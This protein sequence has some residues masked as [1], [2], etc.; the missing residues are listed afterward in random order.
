MTPISYT[1]LQFTSSI[2]FI[3]AIVHTFCAGFFKKLAHKYENNI[4]INHSNKYKYKLFHVLS[5]VELIFVLWAIV[6]ILFMLVNEGFKS[7]LSYIH[8]LRFIEPFFVLILMLVTGTKPIM[9]V[10]NIV[11][12]YVSNYLYKVIKLAKGISLYFICLALIPI[13]GSLISEPAAMTISALMLNQH[14]FSKNLSQSFKYT[15]LA[16]LFVNISI[17]GA[18][19]SFAAPPIL[20]VAHA[21]NWNTFYIFDTFGLKAILAV[22]I[23]TFIAIGLFYNNLAKQQLEHSSIKKEDK[24]HKNIILIHIIILS[25]VIIFAHNLIALALILLGFIAFINVYKDCPKPMMINQ[26][27][28]VFGFLASLVIIGGQQAWWLQPL[29][30]NMTSM[31]IFFGASV[32]TAVTDNAAITYLASLVSG[33]SED[34][35]YS[36][37]A[38]A[39]S[40]GG[41]TVIANAPNPIGASILQSNFKANIIKPSLLLLYALVPT[42]VCIFVFLPSN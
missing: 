38:G 4:N 5:E 11:S 18:L 26:S 24:I 32:L 41:L 27:I 30:L 33:L 19:T 25:C 6:L 10:T 21:W 7:T 42:L 16:V 35:K 1:L 37:V 3:I 29:L 22:L 23:N 12:A 28:M 39:I 2:I 8:G 31:Q 13:L 17:G 36:I 34:F 14:F 20:M 15:S 40:G 9:Y